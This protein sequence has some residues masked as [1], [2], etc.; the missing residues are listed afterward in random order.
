MELQIKLC[1]LWNKDLPL[2]FPPNFK[3]AGSRWAMR[4]ISIE[5]SSSP[6]PKEDWLTVGLF[7]LLPLRENKNCVV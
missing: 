2:E 7:N 6:R 4:I 5:F 1:N 3:Y